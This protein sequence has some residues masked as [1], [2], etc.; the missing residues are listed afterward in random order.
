WFQQREI[1]ADALALGIQARELGRK[2]FCAPG[3][4]DL[5]EVRRALREVLAQSL[6]Q[7]SR[8]PDEHPAVPEIIACGEEL[9]GTLLIGFLREAHH[10]YQLRVQLVAGL[11]IAVTGL[12]AGGLNAHD[13][14]VVCLLR[15]FDSPSNDLMK[16][17]LVADD[18]VRRKHADDG[19]RIELL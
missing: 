10:T 1:N 2:L 17:L 18:M 16:L 11:D 12:G 3:G 19:L 5:F 8:A 13:H 9:I 15:Y 7:G 6:A 14:D 4:S